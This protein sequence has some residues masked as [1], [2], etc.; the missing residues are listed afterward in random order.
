MLYHKLTS[1]WEATRAVA[2]AVT[3]E[4][5]VLQQ[6]FFGCV[7]K[8]PS[9][10]WQYNAFGSDHPKYL[11]LSQVTSK[12]LN[13]FKLV[14]FVFIEE[15]NNYFLLSIYLLNLRSLSEFLEGSA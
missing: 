7:G 5:H 3:V 14:C 6:I 4:N 2:V 13:S 10:D 9:V 15:T 1:I 8:A 12:T 11:S